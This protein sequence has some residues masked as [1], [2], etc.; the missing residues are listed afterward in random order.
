MLFSNENSLL[1]RQRF[2]VQKGRYCVNEVKKCTPM[3]CNPE[4]GRGL[5]MRRITWRDAGKTFNERESNEWSS[6]LN[7]GMPCPKTVITEWMG[8]RLFK[9]VVSVAEVTLYLKIR[10]NS[11][12]ERAWTNGGWRDQG[13]LWGR[14]NKNEKPLRIIGGTAEIR[15]CYHSNT[16]Q[17]H[18]QLRQITFF[19]VLRP[20]S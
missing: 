20:P 11:H 13:L 14:L 4:S 2:N 12:D 17:G 5:G 1:F 6:C 15:T 19:S 7:E 10:D 9:Y 16:S 3:K 18:H 8:C